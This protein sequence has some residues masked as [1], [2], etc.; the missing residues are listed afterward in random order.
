MLLTNR[1][2][3][4]QTN[5]CHRK[6]NLQGG[7]EYI[8]ISVYCGNPT[9][10]LYQPFVPCVLYNDKLTQWPLIYSPRIITV[11]FDF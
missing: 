11:I 3:N 9:K 5:Q 6:N 2:S 10:G 4:T 8:N 7:N 1:H